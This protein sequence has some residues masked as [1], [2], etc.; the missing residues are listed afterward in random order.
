MREDNLHK[1][2]ALIENGQNQKAHKLAHRTFTSYRF[3]LSGSKY[4]LQMLMQLPILAQCSA[5]QPALAEVPALTKWIAD[6][7]EHRQTPEY[8]AAVA[9]SKKRSSEHIRLS[10][11]IWQ[12]SKH[13]AKAKALSRK[14]RLVSFD[15][16]SSE[17]QGMVKAYEGGC[18][19]RSLQNLLSQKSST[20]RG[21]AACV[22][23]LQKGQRWCHR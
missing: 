23:H 17:E 16:L 2:N 4:L 3:H 7:Q 9:L 20:Y 6:L 11:Q 19:E 5:S 13:L 21:V 15:V 8:Q 10:Q 18:L 22:S 1:H 12:Q 14:A